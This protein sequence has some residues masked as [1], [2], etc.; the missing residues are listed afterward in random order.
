MVKADKETG[1]VLTKA[2]DIKEM[3]NTRG[4]KYFQEEL[5]N[6][7]LNLQMISAIEGETAEEKMQSM[8]V[9]QKTATALYEVLA[10]ILG[11]PNQVKTNTQYLDMYA[12]SIYNAE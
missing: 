8:A 6:K 7:I 4:W 12:G 2:E 1:E 10:G 5:H 9:N 11:T 3:M